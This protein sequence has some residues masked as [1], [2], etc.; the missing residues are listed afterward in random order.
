ML[1]DDNDAVIVRST[2]DLAH[3]LGLRVVAEGVED[4]ETWMQL[5]E[6]GCDLAQGFYISRPV[7][8]GQLGR[9]VRVRQAELR[10]TELRQAELQAGR[11][12]DTAL[13]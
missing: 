7:P 5:A 8:A 9:V 4:Y 2:I 3:N 6:L 11:A 13:P 12:S 10:Q 1:T